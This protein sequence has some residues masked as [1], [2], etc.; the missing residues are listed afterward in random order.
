[1]SPSADALTVPRMRAVKDHHAQPRV[2]VFAGSEIGYLSTYTQ[3]AHQLGTLLANSKVELVYGGTSGGL[4]GVAAES[5]YHAGGRVIGVVPKDQWK[6]LESEYCTVRYEVKTLG[7]RKALMMSLADAFVVLPGGLGTND[8]LSDVLTLRHIGKLD[9]PI[10]LCNTNGYFDPLLHWLEHMYECGL[11]TSDPCA[12]LICE[13]TPTRLLSHLGELAPPAGDRDPVISWAP[14][15]AQMAHRLDSLYAM[16]QRIYE[17]GG[18]KWAEL[19]TQYSLRHYVYEEAAE[20]AQVLHDMGPDFQPDSKSPRVA[21][22]RGQLIEELGDLLS[23]V[24]VHCYL[25]E[26]E[27]WFTLDDVL[28]QLRAK[29]LHRNPHVFGKARAETVAEVE[30]IWSA[31]KKQE[32]ALVHA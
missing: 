11:A 6:D 18:C 22:L 9:K 7:D 26:R 12:Y 24:L 10:G 20:V 23:Q 17:P 19:Q 32:K 15:V 31:I 30:R 5:A 25:A 29:L 16:V 21:E 1:M 28:E 8:E 2:C 4:M 3:A 27:D 13:P 14:V